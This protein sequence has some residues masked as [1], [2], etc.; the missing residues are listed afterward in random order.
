ML[1]GGR[2]VSLAGLGTT[3]AA[4][5]SAMMGDETVLIGLQRIRSASFGFPAAATLPCEADVTCDGSAD[6]LDLLEFLQAFSACSE[7]GACDELLADFDQNGEIDILDF[8][9]FMDAF[10]RGC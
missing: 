2:W 6:I 8:L 4:S 7:G 10:D 9:A 5:D 3:G 1:S